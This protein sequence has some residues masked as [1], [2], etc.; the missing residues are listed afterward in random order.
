MTS[1]TINYLF[2]SLCRWGS[3]KGPLEVLFRLFWDSYVEASHDAA[4]TE[5]A[6]LSLH[7]EG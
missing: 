2:F 3:L 7:F 4:V 6:A 1:M 5:S